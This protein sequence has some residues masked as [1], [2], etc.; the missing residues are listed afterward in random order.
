ME[1]RVLYYYA[2]SAPVDEEVDEPSNI[3]EENTSI[4]EE[5]VPAIPITFSKDQVSLDDVTLELEGITSS[6][7]ATLE[8][9]ENELPYGR[10][11][12]LDIE[13]GSINADRELRIWVKCSPI[14][15][16]QH[17]V[18]AGTTIETI[19]EQ[20]QAV[21]LKKYNVPI[22]II[23]LRLLEGDNITKALPGD[24]VVGVLINDLDNVVVEY[25]TPSEDVG[26]ESEDGTHS[27]MC[28]Y[29][30]SGP[31]ANRDLKRHIN[32]TRVDRKP[33][34]PVSKNGEE[35]NCP[36]TFYDSLDAVNHVNLAISAEQLVDLRTFWQR[37]TKDEED[38]ISRWILEEEEEK[39]RKAEQAS[40]KKPRKRKARKNK[41]KALKEKEAQEQRERERALQEERDRE[42]RERQRAIELQKQREQAIRKF[43]RDLFADIL[44]R[45]EI[46][47]GKKK[48]KPT[49]APTA[50]TK[51]RKKKRGG[52]DQKVV[53]VNGNGSTKILNAV[54]KFK[55]EEES[56]HE[57]V[58]EK[59]T[60]SVEVRRQP[61][62]EG[63]PKYSQSM[64]A[65]LE[66]ELDVYLAKLKDKMEFCQQ[67][68]KNM[69]RKIDGIV[70]SLWK[71][72]TVRIYGSYAT[73][74]CIPASDLDLVILGAEGLVH[75][76][77]HV[78]YD[79][80]EKQPWVK[81]LDMIETARVPVIKVKSKDENI[82]TDI[83]FDADIGMT[84]FPTSDGLLV[85]HPGIVSADLISHY[86][87]EY[88]QLAPLAVVIKQ[89]LYDHELN[90]AYAGG[91][92]SY[93]LVLMITSFLQ[94]RAVA[95]AAAVH[96][97]AYSSS[98]SA[99]S[100]I[101]FGGGGRFKNGNGGLDGNG[102][103]LGTLLLDFLEFYGKSFDF[104]KLGI[105]ISN[106]GSYFQLR[107]NDY[108]YSNCTLVIIDPLNPANNVSQSITGMPKVKAFF[109][110]VHTN[111]IEKFFQNFTPATIL[112]RF[113]K[114]DPS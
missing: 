20:I 76:M 80:L 47:I 101:Y 60:T 1:S 36:L 34:L 113:W 27:F 61:V 104:Q 7:N 84:A 88:P 39:K 91:L 25:T 12:F 13:S 45:A 107:E 4:V 57:P 48:P 63:H 69:H 89:L 19:C 22:N 3:K 86:M 11:P 74:L 31:N 108:R 83:S 46:E 28:P 77:L 64:L 100:T 58:T 24:L 62:S 8:A 68:A 105:S 23:G 111:L 6:G 70:K 51:G 33:K 53:A 44:K 10:D 71:D 55:N 17:K 35:I 95:A 67:N 102:A 72:A 30:F 42:E 40:K 26:S 41:A 59:P 52:A 2:L 87:R 82:A 79:E 99:T 103:T 98:T 92:S 37:E 112:Y 15:K 75:E 65:I 18:K 9:A 21:V 81:S 114:T 97:T 14:G 54:S 56:V 5:V 43:G 90:N 93:C 85:R 78:L 49:A 73:N 110:R 66:N 29:K 50:G 109:E 16:F 96:S 38:E 94:M 106:G 32:A